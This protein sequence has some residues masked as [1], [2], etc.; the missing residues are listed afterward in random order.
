MTQQSLDF[1]K[2]NPG[3]YV[4]DNDICPGCSMPAVVFPSG[5]MWAMR[6]DFELSADAAAY[7]KGTQIV[8]GPHSVQQAAMRRQIDEQVQ[9]ELEFWKDMALRSLAAVRFFGICAKTKGDQGA[10]DEMAD[11]Q[12]SIENVQAAGRAAVSTVA[13]S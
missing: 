1:A 8:S 13:Q 10:A 12:R 4:L 3:L 5:A 2:A 6:P 7:G 9:G 11:I